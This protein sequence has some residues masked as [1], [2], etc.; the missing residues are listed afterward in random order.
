[1]DADN[2]RRPTQFHP[3][4]R[5]YIAIKIGSQIFYTSYRLVDCHISSSLQR[6]IFILFSVKNSIGYDIIKGERERDEI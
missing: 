3:F 5:S 4:L 6:E 1:M 2:T